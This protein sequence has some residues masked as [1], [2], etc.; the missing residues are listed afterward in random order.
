M[1]KVNLTQERL[2]ELLDYDLDTGQFYWKVSSANCIKVGAIAGYTN[3]GYVVICIS[4]KHYYAHRL[5]FLYMEGYL[6]ENDV[7]HIN[8]I[9]DDNRWKN[10]RHTTRQCNNR[11]RKIHANNKSGITGVS[12]EKL[13]NKWVSQITIDGENFNLGRF[14][15]LKEAAQARWEAEV[16]YGFSNCN[17]TS[18]AYCYLQKVSNA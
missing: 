6:P 13:Y 17:T 5:A 4:R 3:N 12:W 15:I 9:S 11:N 7:D 1:V 10:L 14:K 18:S 2:R 16:K 8:R